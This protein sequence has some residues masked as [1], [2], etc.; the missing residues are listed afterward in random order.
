MEPA[1]APDG[2]PILR[3]VL[4]IVCC[5]AVLGLGVVLAYQTSKSRP[6][7]AAAAASSALEGR[8]AAGSPSIP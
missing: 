2:P 8:P 5:L 6:R 1:E 4:M 7:N 3:M